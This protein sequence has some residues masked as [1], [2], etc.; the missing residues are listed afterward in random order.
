MDEV[1]DN[2]D[3]QLFSMFISKSLQATKKRSQRYVIIIDRRN[4]LNLK[5]QNM[6]YQQPIIDGRKSWRDKIYFIRPRKSYKLIR[7]QAKCEL[8]P[9]QCLGLSSKYLF[10]NHPDKR[11][12]FGISLVQQISNKIV[13]QHI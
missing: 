1:G 6:N 7:H 10:P 12:L 2:V 8:Y 4:P 9:E 13:T 3:E 5:K 11:E